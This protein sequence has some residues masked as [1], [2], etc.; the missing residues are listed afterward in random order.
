MVVNRHRFLDMRTRSW[1]WLLWGALNLHPLGL[2]AQGTLQEY[3][4]VHLG[5]EVRML[6]VGDSV[7]TDRAAAAGY[8]RI[9]EL[10]DVLSD[11]R[12]GSEVR[13]LEQH[14]VGE[15]IPV[16]A[17][18][19]DVLALALEVA[20]A[21]DG[22]FDPTI[23]PLT[24]LW[25][26]AKRTG[27]PATDSAVAAARQR[28]GYRFVELDSAQSRVRLLGEGMRLDLG[29]IAKGWILDDALATVRA[30][31][32]ENALI[33]AGGD[34]VVNGAPP[35]AIGWR[36]A[37]HGSHG[38]ATALCTSGAVSTSGPS[39]QWIPGTGGTRES[40]VIRPSTGRGTTNGHEVT[41]FGTRAAVTD[42]LA[43]ALTLVPPAARQELARRFRVTFAE[44]RLSR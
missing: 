11:W 9:A 5:M 42:A 25:R 3:R 10:E 20:R 15:W 13:R 22:A 17:S 28:V 37:Y 32:V 1:W 41:V 21:T 7:R 18:L 19:R 12:A 35:G 24:V 43:T 38:E 40:H 2:V 29:A 44:G 4:E 27:I 36:I 14:P 6:L 23:G 8:D 30:L 34:V 33:E 16:S 26:E 31:G 39:V